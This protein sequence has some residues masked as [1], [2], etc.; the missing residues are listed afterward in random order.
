MSKH[1]ASPEEDLLKDPFSLMESSASISIL[2]G[3]VDVDTKSTDVTAKII[4]N[5]KK[6][7]SI[8]VCLCLSTSIETHLYYRIFKAIKLA[9]FY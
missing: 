1:E 5:N 7:D 6:K 8:V 4:E 2:S 9:L 3:C